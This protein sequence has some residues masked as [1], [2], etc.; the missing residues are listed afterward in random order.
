MTRLQHPPP[1]P[2]PPPPV[3]VSKIMILFADH[4][5]VED[6]QLNC[7][8]YF[9]MGGDP[10]ATDKINHLSAELSHLESQNP[11]SPN[12][13]LE[14]VSTCIGY[15]VPSASHIKKVFD[16]VTLAKSS[17][18]QVSGVHTMAQCSLGT[19]FGFH[20][21]SFTGSFIHSSM[22]AVC[23]ASGI[24]VLELSLP[25]GQPDPE[26]AA[27]F[28]LAKRDKLYMIVVTSSEAVGGCNK[29]LHAVQSN[30]CQNICSADKEFTPTLSHNTARNPQ[31]KIPSYVRFVPNQDGHPAFYCHNSHL[32]SWEP[33]DCYTVYSP[34]HGHWWIASGGGV[35]WDTDGFVSGTVFPPGLE[36]G[37]FPY[38]PAFPPAPPSEQTPFLQPPP[39]HPP[40]PY[41]IKP[42]SAASGTRFKLDHQINRAQT[43]A[44]TSFLEYSDVQIVGSI[45]AE[46]ANVMPFLSSAGVQKSPLFPNAAVYSRLHPASLTHTLAGFFPPNSAFLP[47]L[48]PPSLNDGNLPKYLKQFTVSHLKG[49]LYSALCRLIELDAEKV[50]AVFKDNAVGRWFVA[51]SRTMKSMEKDALA[52]SRCLSQVVNVNP[53]LSV[54]VESKFKYTPPPVYVA[55]VTA[56]QNGNCFCGVRDHVKTT[57][58]SCLLHFDNYSNQWIHPLH[59][60]LEEWKVANPNHVLSPFLCRD[61]NRKEKQF[62]T[63]ISSSE[64]KQ[65]LELV[66]Q[67][68]LV[69]WNVAGKPTDVE[70]KAATELYVIKMPL[71]TVLRDATWLQ[72]QI[73][74]LLPT[75]NLISTIA[76]KFGT[77]V[78]LRMYHESKAGEP[79]LPINQSFFISVIKTVATNGKSKTSGQHSKLCQWWIDFKSET[80]VPLLPPLD[81]VLFSNM[82]V[83]AAERMATDYQRHITKDLHNHMINTLFQLYRKYIRDNHI[84]CDLTAL[85][86]AARFELQHLFV[87]D[88][89]LFVE[90][91]K[92]AGTRAALPKLPLPWVSVDRVSPDHLTK[93]F[94][95]DIAEELACKTLAFIKD[96]EAWF[97][98]L[99]P[100]CKRM[101]KFHKLSYSSGHYY[102]LERNRSLEPQNIPSTKEAPS[103][104]APKPFHMKAA[105]RDA[106]SKPI[107]FLQMSVMVP[108][109]YR[110]VDAGLAHPDQTDPLYGL[111][112]FRHRGIVKETDSLVRSKLQASINSDIDRIQRGDFRI[113]TYGSLPQGATKGWNAHPQTTFKEK[114][115]QLDS[116]DLAMMTYK[117][118][119]RGSGWDTLCLSLNLPTDCL[120]SDFKVAGIRKQSILWGTVLPA[121]RNV[122]KKEE[123]GSQEDKSQ[124]RRFGGS[125]MVNSISVSLHCLRPK[126]KALDPNQPMLTPENLVLPADS[127]VISGDPGVVTPVMWYMALNPGSAPGLTPTQ[128]PNISSKS[129]SYHQANENRRKKE[130]EVAEGSYIYHA[131][132]LLS[133]P[134]A[135]ARVAVIAAKKRAKKKRYLNNRR[136]RT[137]AEQKKLGE[138]IG[139]YAFEKL[140]WEEQLSGLSFKFGLAEWKEKTQQK[141]AEMQ[142]VKIREVYEKEAKVKIDAE[143]AKL[144]VASSKTTSVADFNKSSKVSFEVYPILYELYCRQSHLRFLTYQGEQRTLKIFMSYLRG[145]YRR[146]QIV[147][148]IGHAGYG[149]NMKG[150]V[151]G[152]SRKLVREA[153]KTFT[154]VTVN[155]GKTTFCC[156]GCQGTGKCTDILDLGPSPDVVSKEELDYIRN[157]IIDH[158]IGTLFETGADGRTVKH[159]ARIEKVLRLLGVTDEEFADLEDED[160]DRYLKQVDTNDDEEEDVEIME[161]EDCEEREQE[162]EIEMEGNLESSDEDVAVNQEIDDFLLGLDGMNIEPELWYGDFGVEDKLDDLIHDLSDLEEDRMEVD[163]SFGGGDCGLMG[164]GSEPNPIDKVYKTNPAHYFLRE[165]VGDVG[166]EGRKRESFTQSYVTTTSK[167]ILKLKN[168]AFRVGWLEEFPLSERVRKAFQNGVPVGK[169]LRAVKY[170]HKCGN[171]WE[172]DKNAARNIWTLFWY[173]RFNKMKRPFPFQ[174]T[175][176]KKDE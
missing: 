156:S 79:M 33:P 52:M 45:A 115:F 39:L 44:L 93:L 119:P 35:S 3:D 20:Q 78:G 5:T 14:A 43:L 110:S 154:T 73:E 2:E 9:S 81:H 85:R 76:T 107:S 89:K 95:L 13:Y 159:W 104:K 160:I 38:P 161:P 37:P 176:R 144:A 116:T 12:E 109:Y 50:F 66:L 40:I 69:E 175:R 59:L 103:L 114:S 139:A 34:E 147:L 148:A 58:R 77:N 11:N 17:G 140:S 125:M 98:K 99:L 55:T 158:D 90:L 132:K 80:G 134:E 166:A 170:C 138:Q 171:I 174:V 6:Q 126:K 133:V 8:S 53:P 118:F 10:L 48:H 173:L 72:P 30:A 142:R 27:K 64:Y 70:G 136:N 88:K 24:C 56:V 152:P 157:L 113:E 111:R 100:L 82:I 22:Q 31:P 129:G 65:Y 68:K 169:P 121:I 71:T 67:P 16:A 130:V 128:V 74:M 135:N 120:Q 47:Q 4:Y 122:F 46:H 123:I 145:N 28:D 63:A 108:E 106:V 165:G 149:G 42:A 1:P 86:N 36:T 92:T 91:R 105:V 49:P 97:P 87:N 51:G 25:N 131:P 117:Y 84:S 101:F 15:K 19:L 112:F 18:L 167:N 62:L 26:Y 164:D 153:Q 143:F 57:S 124:P 61:V 41:Y 141:Y 150:T 96:L 163:S 32:S 60:W 21:D 94:T 75:I 127:I 83:Y 162:K 172:R 168:K 29:S 102:L 155:E 137:A 151:S 23:D 146:D 7:L 54:P